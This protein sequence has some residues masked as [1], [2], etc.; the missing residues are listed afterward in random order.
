V[1]PTGNSG[2]VGSEAL[3]A[4]DG[5]AQRRQLAATAGAVPMT[6]AQTAVRVA[7]YL[8]VSL[9]NLVAVST[10]WARSADI[11]SPAAASR[12]FGLLGAGATLG[13]LLGSVLAAPLAAMPLLRSAGGPSLLP[14]LAA[15]AALELAG[16]AAARYR[17][18]RNAASDPVPLEDVAVHAAGQA[19]HPS[20]G[21]ARGHSSGG[22]AP[23]VSKVGPDPYYSMKTMDTPDESGT[24]SKAAASSQLSRRPGFHSAGGWLDQL[25]ARTLEGYR[26]IRCDVGL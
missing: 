22:L 8:A 17:V 13:Q 11:F 7:F 2:L 24:P 9:L 4:A 1:Q 25:F 18:S 16:Q 12:L 10:L 26:L 20:V 23:I 21:A 15:A 5:Q 19:R 3:S 14:L 6:S